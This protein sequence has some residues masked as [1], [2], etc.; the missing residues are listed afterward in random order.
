MAE[1]ETDHV[2]I[3]EIDRAI[4]LKNGQPIDILTIQQT[5][6]ADITNTI[7]QHGYSTQPAQ[8]DPDGTLA[9][10]QQCTIEDPRP[11]EVNVTLNQVD[12]LAKESG[13]TNTPV[14]QLIS[15]NRF[16]EAQASEAIQQTIAQMPAGE[17]KENAELWY[18]VAFVPGFEPL[19]GDR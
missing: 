7:H 19:N 3:E 8:I 9:Y 16:T 18:K 6:L 4:I 15:Q 11:C 1:S 5:E 14:D 2:A 17:L 10:D 13:L 12:E